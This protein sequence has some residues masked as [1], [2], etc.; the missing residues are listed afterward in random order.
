MSVPTSEKAEVGSLESV[1]PTAAEAPA[2]LRAVVAAPSPGI[3]A[4]SRIRSP[5]RADVTY[6]TFHVRLSSAVI[7]PYTSRS[8]ALDAAWW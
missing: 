2:S 3:A 4:A 6:E 7:E 1:L 8:T 5:G